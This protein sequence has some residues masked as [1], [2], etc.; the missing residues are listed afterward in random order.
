MD[1]RRRD[2]DN[3]TVEAADGYR[4]GSVLGGSVSELPAVI[5]TPAQNT[6]IRGESAAMAASGRDSGNARQAAG[7]GLI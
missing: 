6:A 4:V 5:A 7:A 1:A 3:S 2:C